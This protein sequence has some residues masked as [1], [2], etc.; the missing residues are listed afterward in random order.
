MPDILSKKEI[1]D[2]ILNGFI[3]VDDV[4]S[5]EIADAVSVELIKNSWRSGC[6]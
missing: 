4:F 2:F 6:P 1:E 3:R 5:K